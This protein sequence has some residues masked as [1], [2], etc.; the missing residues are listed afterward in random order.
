M[1]VVIIIPTY[2]ERENI[3]KTLDK[4]F[5]YTKLIKN[6]DFH[7]LVVDDNSPDGTGDVVKT[8]QKKYKNIELITGNKQGLGVAYSRGM[9]YAMNKMNADVVFE[10][11][12]DGQHD[13]IYIKD[14]MQKID[15]GYDYVLGSRYVKG[16]SIPKEWGTHRKFIS[17]FGSLFA[18]IILGTPQVKDYT[19]GYKASRVKGF[20]DSIDLD[21]LL[22]K[23]YAYKITLLHRML[24][25]GA[26]TTEIPIHF[27]SREKNFSKSTIEDLFDSFLVVMK[28]RFGVKK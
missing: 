16:G 10:F 18:R 5:K 19:G 26:K 11:D 24:K 7:V 12:A 23:R 3:G 14:F 9:K 15:E 13:P 25:K 4:V 2:N 17:Y 1:K 22:S 27:K 20:L 8:Y 6:H 21:Y 28:L